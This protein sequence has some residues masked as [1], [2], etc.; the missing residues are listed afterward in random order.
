[1]IS[2]WIAAHA[3]LSPDMSKMITDGSFEAWCLPQG[4]ISQ[5]WR[6][7]AAHRPGLITKTGL[8]TFVDPRVEGGNSTRRPQGR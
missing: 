1:M 4:V 8:S 5:L 3:G 6:E 7:I 2:R